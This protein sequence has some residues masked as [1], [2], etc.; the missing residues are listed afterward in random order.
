MAN[1]EVIEKI[2]EYANM[3]NIMEFIAIA[4]GN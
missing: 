4:L 3:E 2:H 1:A